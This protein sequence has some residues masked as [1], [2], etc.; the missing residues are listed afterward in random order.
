MHSELRRCL[1]SYRRTTKGPSSAI[2]ELDTIAGTIAFAEQVQKRR[3]FQA[4]EEWLA[5]AKRE[6]ELM[7]G[8]Y[9]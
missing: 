4:R 1:N 5:A 3:M 9:R 6:N 2:H 7:K 8:R